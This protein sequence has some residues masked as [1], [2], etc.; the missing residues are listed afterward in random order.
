[1][2]MYAMQQFLILSPAIVFLVSLATAPACAHESTHVKVSWSSHVSNGTL[3]WAFTLTIFL[4][5]CILSCYAVHPST[6]YTL[7]VIALIFLPNYLLSYL[8]A[9]GG[10]LRKWSKNSMISYDSVPFKIHTVL[11]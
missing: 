4:E 9:F 3:C 8:V 10:I 6:N 7:I 11:E 2:Y 1:M 5:S